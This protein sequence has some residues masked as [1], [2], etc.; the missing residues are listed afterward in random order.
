MPPDSALRQALGLTEGPVLGFVGELRSKKGAP[1]IL[2]CFR[3]VAGHTPAQ[4]LVVGAVRTE[5][6]AAL[7]QFTVDEPQLA[8]RVHIVPYVRDDAT[9]AAI[10]NLID[11]VLCPSLWEGM[12]NAV[13][14]AMACARPVLASDA[15]GI[16]DLITHGETGWI[17]S[18][19]HLHRLGEALGELLELDANGRAAVGERARAHVLAYFPP[20]REQRELLEAYG[21]ALSTSEMRRSA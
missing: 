9:L 17:A 4:L 13:L 3:Q 16:P 1:F 2:E 10:Y 6:R 14:E 15:G 5:E 12:P 19:H 21:A 18:R 8:G 20:E 7:E 11:V